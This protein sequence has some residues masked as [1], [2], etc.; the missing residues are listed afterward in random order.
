VW[1]LHRATVAHGGHVRTGLEDTFY[2]PDG[3]RAT[4]NG[5]LVEQ[6]VKVVRE[7]G[8][9]PATAAQSR[10]LFGIA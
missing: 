3:S 2:L 5:Q 8:R 9:E 10:A 7:G 1:E 4:S 6:L